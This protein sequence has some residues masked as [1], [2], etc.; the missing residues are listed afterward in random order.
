[1][2]KWM[3]YREKRACEKQE[4]E[5]WR[6]VCNTRGY[7]GDPSPQTPI[8]TNYPFAPVRHTFSSR[9]LQSVALLTFIEHLSLRH[10]PAAT[11]IWTIH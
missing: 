8:R 9:K 5:V 6:A 2:K 1:M 10:D 11:I 7:N 3:G 4:L